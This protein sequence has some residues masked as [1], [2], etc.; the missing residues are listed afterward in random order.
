[1]I[2]VDEIKRYLK[3]N[4][5]D[6]RYNHTLGVVETAT[7]LAIL[8]EVDMVKAEVA[9]L[10][11]DVA[12]NF[13]DDELEKIIR[14]ENIELSVDE[15]N[16]KS[17]W[18]AIVA[19]IVGKKEFFIEDEEILSAMRWHTTGKENMTKLEKIVYLADLIEPSRDFPGVNE[20]RDIAEKN[21]DLAVLEGLTHT[22]KYLLQK[23]FA[24]DVNTIKARNYLLYNKE[25]FNSDGV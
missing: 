8:H 13:S 17:I 1:M 16:T 14:D 22:T 10:C 9:A 4:L 24:I 12:K 25:K 2:G 15:M 19:P 18:H 11:H 3:K 6:S 20:I 7:K 5:K 21:L 23:G